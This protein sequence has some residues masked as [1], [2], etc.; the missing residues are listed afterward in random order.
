MSTLSEIAEQ[1]AE[2][3]YESRLLS[4][5]LFE[6]A[7]G[8]EKQCA[9]L[10]HLTEG[11]RDSSMRNAQAMFLNANKALLQAAKALE[12]AA[13]DGENWCGAHLTHKL[14]RRMK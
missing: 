5:Q 9:D 14:V 8:L 1:V 7:K 13:T 11:T 10:A 3:S 4:Y 2:W 12:S 6:W